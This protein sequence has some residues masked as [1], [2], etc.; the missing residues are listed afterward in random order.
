MGVSKWSD[1]SDVQHYHVTVTQLRRM[2]LAGRTTANNQWRIQ[3]GGN[4][5][6]PPPNLVC[7]WDLAAWSHQS[8]KNFAWA[9]GHWV[10]DSTY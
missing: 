8:A 7:L 3:R 1:A 2:I 4:P 5:A 6:M 9:D 10:I